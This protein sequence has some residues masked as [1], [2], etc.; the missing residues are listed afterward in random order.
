[1]TST[2]TKRHKPTLHWVV[3]RPEDS[4]HSGMATLQP[5]LLYGDAQWLL[6][7]HVEPY[8]MIVADTTAEWGVE[9]E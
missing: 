3:L 2:K 1:M 9:Y 8:L 5:T 6:F 4:R 7:S